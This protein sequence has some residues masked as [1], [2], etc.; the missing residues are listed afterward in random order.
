[1]Q[2][3]RPFFIRKCGFCNFQSESARPK[4]AEGPLNK[5]NPSG[6][7]IFS[8]GLSPRE[9]FFYLFFSQLFCIPLASA[10]R[11][12]LIIWEV[13]LVVG[14]T[15]GNCCWVAHGGP[16]LKCKALGQVMDSPHL[17]WSM[18]G[19]YQGSGKMTRGPR[20]QGVH[21]GTG[22]RPA[23]DAGRLMPGPLQ[24]VTVISEPSPFS[25]C[26]LEKSGMFL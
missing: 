2:V 22:E 25:P 19:G 11:M 16:Q 26:H 23:R 17:E 12:S 4:R 24:P 3:L 15:V 21:K 14:V 13:D 7:S 20:K 10:D 6:D 5:A 1:M 8:G 9:F 18:G